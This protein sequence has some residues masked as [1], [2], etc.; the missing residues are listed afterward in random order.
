MDIYFRTK[1]LILSQ[2]RSPDGICNNCHSPDIDLDFERS[3]GLGICRRCRS[4]NPDKYKTITKTEAKEVRFHAD[5]D[6]PC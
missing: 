3:F 5:P 4:E 1:W 2:R 6:P